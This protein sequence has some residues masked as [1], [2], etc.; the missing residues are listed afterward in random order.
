LT[1]RGETKTKN[2][3]LKLVKPEVE[4]LAPFWLSALKDRALIELPPEFSPQLPREGGSFFI[5]ET[6]DVVR[7]YYRDS[8]PPILHACAV[9]V[10]TLPDVGLAE[11]PSQSESNTMEQKLDKFFLVF[12]RLHII[13]SFLCVD[14]VKTNNSE[15]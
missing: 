6:R 1:F 3:L 5:N 13:A 10:S 8:W 14:S 12:G 11:S 4:I 2:H 15:F 7:V 9:C